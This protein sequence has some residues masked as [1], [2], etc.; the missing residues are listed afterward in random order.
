M[1]RNDALKGKRADLFEWGVIARYPE[2][3]F[4]VGDPKG[5]VQAGRREW[6]HFCRNGSHSRIED[7]LQ[8][9]QQRKNA[10]EREAA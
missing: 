9:T 7:A 8:A 10:G 4:R 5:T 6:E 3:V 2:L 1:G